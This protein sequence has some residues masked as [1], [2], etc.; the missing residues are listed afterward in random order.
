M[1]GSLGSSGAIGPAAFVCQ[2]PL[3]TPDPFVAQWG[4][5]RH[6]PKVTGSNPVKQA[7]VA[8]G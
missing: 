8:H 5:H 4:E 6:A 7:K 1:V 3:E 2:M